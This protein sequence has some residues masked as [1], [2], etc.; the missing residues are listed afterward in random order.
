MAGSREIIKKN[1]YSNYR[2]KRICKGNKKT[3]LKFESNRIENRGQYM[4]VKRTR[5]FLPST[6]VNH[7]DLFASLYIRTPSDTLASLTTNCK[8]DESSSSLKSTTSHRCSSSRSVSPIRSLLIYSD[9]G[10][11]FL[12]EHI[13]TRCEALATRDRICSMH[14]AVVLQDKV[15][16]NGPFSKYGS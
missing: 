13:Q 12:S 9:C 14:R 15:G 8:K 2:A 5:Y 16:K 11:R 7:R 3:E 4:F 1:I 10:T 6:S